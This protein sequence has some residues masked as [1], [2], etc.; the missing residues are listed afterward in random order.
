MSKNMACDS[1]VDVSPCS[2]VKTFNFERKH[3]QI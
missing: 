1:L 2:R 3:M